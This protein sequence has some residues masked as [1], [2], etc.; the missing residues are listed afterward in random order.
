MNCRFLNHGLHHRALAVFWLGLFCR[1]DGIAPIFAHCESHAGDGEKTKAAQPVYFY[2]DHALPAL[3]SGL[4]ES[5]QVQELSRLWLQ[6]A[7]HDA[8][9]VL[10]QTLRTGLN[11]IV[12]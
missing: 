1:R 9:G 2:H 6:L 12:T 4:S 3:L 5:W 11:I 7:Q 8:K 10:Q